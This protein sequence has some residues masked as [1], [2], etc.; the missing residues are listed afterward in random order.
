MLLE[1]LSL[2]LNHIFIEKNLLSMHQRILICL[3]GGQDSTALL[4]LLIRLKKS[5]DLQIAV[6]HCDH[7]WYPNS[8][9]IG[10]HISQWMNFNKIDYYQGIV[11]YALHNEAEAR[12]WRYWTVQKVAQFHQFE[13]IMTGHTA[14]DRTETFLYSLLRGSGVKGLQALKW[15]KKICG[16]LFIRPFLSFIRKECKDLCYIKKLPLWVDPSNHIIHWQRNRIRK[17]LLPYLRHYFNLQVD[18]NLAKLIEILHINNLF[19]ENFYFKFKKQ[20]LFLFY[21]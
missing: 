7:F 15:Q 5:W 21:D 1:K 10:S 3:S 20:L 2:R 6:V 4:H 14:T 9:L 17:R 11:C 12:Y 16:I 8:Q 18:K 13:K 19:F